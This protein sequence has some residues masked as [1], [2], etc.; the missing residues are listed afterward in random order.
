MIFFSGVGHKGQIMAG[1]I[2]VVTTVD[3]K[4][5]AAAIAKQLVDE[6]LAACVQVAGP[7]ESTYRWK[8]TVETAQEWQCFIKTELRYWDAV[9]RRI[10]EL[11][12]Y[13]LPEIVATPIQHGSREYLDWLTKQLR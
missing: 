13:E 5:D 4:E 2:Q 9:Q 12:P 6:G 10:R 11:H 3:K 7:V 1:Y 8:G